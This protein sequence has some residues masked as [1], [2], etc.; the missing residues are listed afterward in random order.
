MRCVR[1]FLFCL[2]LTLSADYLAAYYQACKGASPIRAGVD[3]LA[4][5]L[6]LG[7]SIIL[8]GA[9]VTITKVYRQQLWIG[10]SI[11]MIAMGVLSTLKWN[12]ELSKPIGFSVLVHGGSG[13]LYAATYFPVLAPLPVSE[14]AHALAFFSFCR[15]FA[16]VS[17]ESRI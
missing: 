6:T 5:S 7:P 4:M 3:A 12:T 16:S 14:N 13:M 10:W 1:L 11:L 8:T 9:S 2:E 17:S 15:T